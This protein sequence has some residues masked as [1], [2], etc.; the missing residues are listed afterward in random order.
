MIVYDTGVHHLEAVM[1]FVEQY[2]LPWFLLAVLSWVVLRMAARR[3]SFRHA[4]PVGIWTLAVGGI[5]E[6]FFITEKFWNDRFIMVPVGELDLFLLI[7]PFFALGIL[8]IRFLPENAVGRFVMVLV[9][10]MLAVAIE[11][12][13]VELGFLSYSTRW[14]GGHSLVGYLLGLMSA[15][16]FYFVYYR[17]D[18]AK[19]KRW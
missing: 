13:A 16:G 3:D 4:L 11:F 12:L 1:G 8:L 15:L 19:S 5:L 6:H 17:I 14:S 10:S 18:D 9:W 7:G 2:N